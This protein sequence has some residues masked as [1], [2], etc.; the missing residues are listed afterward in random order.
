[1]VII[2]SGKSDNEEFIPWKKLT[3]IMKKD[4]IQW[5]ENHPEDFDDFG[6]DIGLLYDLTN[7]I[8][9][10]IGASSHIYRKLMSENQFKNMK[11]GAVVVFKDRTFQWYPTFEIASENTINRRSIHFRGAPF[12]HYQYFRGSISNNKKIN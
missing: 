8:D 3:S 10:E 7:D 12:V 1:M 9:V 2:I 6:C 11:N 4:Q 5:F